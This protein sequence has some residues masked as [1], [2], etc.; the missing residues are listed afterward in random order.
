MI[1]G[2]YQPTRA[3]VLVTPLDA[4]RIARGEFVKDGSWGLYLEPLGPGI[5]RLFVRSRGGEGSSILG[6]LF[7]C[8]VFDPAHF[9]MER[10]MM[11]GIKKRAEAGGIPSHQAGSGSESAPE[12]I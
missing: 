3:M 9:I 1:V 7:G 12:G 5:T 10:K 6:K 8:L 2:A 4:E 11:L